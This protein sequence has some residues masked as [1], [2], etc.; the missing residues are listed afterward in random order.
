MDLRLGGVR[1][2]A[3]SL[4][5]PGDGALSILAAEGSFALEGVSVSGL[6]G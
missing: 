2:L 1:T 4:P 6:R 5:G 3:N